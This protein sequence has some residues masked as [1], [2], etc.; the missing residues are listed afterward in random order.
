MINNAWDLLLATVRKM[1]LRSFLNKKRRPRS[2]NSCVK[3]RQAVSGRNKT[4]TERTKAGLLGPGQSLTERP[5][6]STSYKENEFALK[7][8]HAPLLKQVWQASMT[9]LVWQIL[10]AALLRS[11]KDEWKIL[12]NTPAT[13]RQGTLH[14]TFRLYELLERPP[15]GI[16]I[17]GCLVRGVYS[18]KGKRVVWGCSALSCKPALEFGIHHLVKVFNKSTTVFHGLFLFFFVFYLFI[19]F[20]QV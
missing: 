18:Q 12:W 6:M 20:L 7:R 13:F 14:R 19:F 15:G 2:N 3:D 4:R 8:N 11:S 1:S 5:G 9:S 10:S 17:Q 16:Y